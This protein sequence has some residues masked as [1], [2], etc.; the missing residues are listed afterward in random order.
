MR[1]EVKKSSRKSKL[2]RE[3]KENINLLKA[4]IEKIGKEADEEELLAWC[5][6]MPLTFIREYVNA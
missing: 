1:N 3:D 6:C 4:F 2:T 5:A